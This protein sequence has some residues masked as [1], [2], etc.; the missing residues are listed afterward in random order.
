V[1]E[2]ELRRILSRPI[3]TEKTRST[4][5]AIQRSGRGIYHEGSSILASGDDP[6]GYSGVIPLKEETILG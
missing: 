1:S 6:E 3:Q 2:G 4:G 5:K